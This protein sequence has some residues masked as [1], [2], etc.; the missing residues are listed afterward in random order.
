MMAI[1]AERRRAP[2]EDM[3]PPKSGQQ[4]DPR[5]LAFAVRMAKLLLQPSELDNNTAPM[6]PAKIFFFIVRFLPIALPARKSH[7]SC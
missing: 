5:S 7:D 1:A 4:Q 6:N 3:A 2:A